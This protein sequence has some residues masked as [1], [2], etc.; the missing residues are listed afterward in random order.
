MCAAQYLVERKKNFDAAMIKK[1]KYEELKAE[2][3]EAR[4]A[5]E[6]KA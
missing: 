6:A 3:R 5:Q 4:A 1:K 2:I